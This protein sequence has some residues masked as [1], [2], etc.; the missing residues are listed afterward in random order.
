MPKQNRKVIKWIFISLVIGAFLTTLLVVGC[1]LSRT[2]EER[3]QAMVEQIAWKLDLNSEQEANASQIADVI[4]QM[5]SALRGEDGENHQALFDLLKAETF[6]AAQAQT[7]Y[8]E[9]RQQIDLYMPQL[10]H[11]YSVFHASLTLEQRQELSD[12]LAWLHDHHHHHH[13]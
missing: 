12:R 5:R 11:A 1:T 2:P 9:G 3:A 6:D 13:Y 4:L 10:I 7:V 8:E